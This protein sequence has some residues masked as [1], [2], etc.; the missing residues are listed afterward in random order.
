MPPAPNRVAEIRALEQKDLPQ[1]AELFEVVLGSGV[2]AA[3]PA[4][5]DFFRRTLFDNPWADPDLKSLVAVDE[6]GR[7]IGFIGAEA[8]RLRF[9][10]RTLRAVVGVHLVVEPAARHLAVGALLLRRLLKGTQDVTLADSA[11]ET[12]RMMWEDFGGHTL[13]LKGF[14]WVRVFRPWRVAA[15]LVASRGRPRLS[16]LWPAAVALDAATMTAGARYLEPT[17]I[18]EAV[19]E[20]TPR[21]LLE[22]LPAISRRL[23]LYP[24]YDETYLEWLFRELG[25]VER[26]ELV[27]RCVYDASGQP[28]GWFVYLLRPGWQSE[29][30]QIA[31]SRNRI[32][33]VLDQLFRHAYAHGSAALR[34]RLEPGI[35]EAV[36]SRRCLLLHRGVALAHSTDPELLCALCSERS[37][38][39]RLEGE[40][41]FDTLI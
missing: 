11:S 41:W 35:V 10:D 21:T 3:S 26:G 2:R 27:A 19:T 15:H 17:R 1:M 13:H 38:V 8:R 6:R 18:Q 33:S 37:L 30:L 25:H 20:L 9:A 34:G 23:T 28:I 39:T 7:P 31:G 12:A 16:T 14:H 22:A 40:W 24:D 36:A 5:I 29:V 4:T 32:G